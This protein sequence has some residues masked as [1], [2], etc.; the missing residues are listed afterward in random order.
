MLMM[1]LMLASA[2]NVE[3]RPSPVPGGERIV[4]AAVS[5]YEGSGLLLDGENTHDGR[6]REYTR[7][8]QCL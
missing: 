2:C 3:E 1:S 7:F 6:I 4:R 5:G 8:R